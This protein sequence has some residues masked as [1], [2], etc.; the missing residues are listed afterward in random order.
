MWYRIE[1]EL[2]GRSVSVEQV[3]DDGHPQPHW[4]NVLYVQSADAGAAVEGARHVLGHDGEAETAPP[5]A[6]SH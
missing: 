4:R 1:L 5:G 2:N 6:P 3:A